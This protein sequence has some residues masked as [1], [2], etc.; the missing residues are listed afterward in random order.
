V[1]QTQ[2]GRSVP[3]AV[4][5][6]TQIALY[7]RGSDAGTEVAFRSLGRRCTVHALGGTRRQGPIVATGKCRVV[8]VALWTMRGTWCIGLRSLVRDSVR[9]DWIG[10]WWS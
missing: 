10:G 5:R 7:G 3:D 1:T 4:S 6:G 9:V 2:I 8:V